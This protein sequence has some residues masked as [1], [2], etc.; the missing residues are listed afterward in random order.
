MPRIYKKNNSYYFTIEAGHDEN[1]G[2]IYLH[3][4][5]NIS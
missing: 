2:K 3:V 5:K 4:K 1:T